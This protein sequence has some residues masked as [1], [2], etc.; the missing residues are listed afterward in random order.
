MSWFVD[1]AADMAIKFRVDKDG[2]TAYE[3]AEGKTFKREVVEFGDCGGQEATAGKG[4]TVEGK[5]CA[6]GVATGN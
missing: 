3:R 5:T 2:K 4:R 1:H 6:C